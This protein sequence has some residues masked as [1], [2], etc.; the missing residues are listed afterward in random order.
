MYEYGGIETS[1][2]LANILMV[3]FGFVFLFGIFT[4]LFGCEEE[5]DETSPLEH[6]DEED[7]FAVL[8]GDE[9]YL[10]AHCTLKEEPLPTPKTSTRTRVMRSSEQD[11]GSN[12]PRVKPKQQAKPC[13]TDVGREAA[14]GL[15]S[16][17]YKKSDANRLVNDMLTQN[18][19]MTSEEVVIEV[20]QK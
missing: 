15:V 2:L 14:M 3:I 9:Q 20:F 13:T 16:L 18:P 6:I 5:V 7:I 12:S 8:T 11:S 4:G 1:H 19:N 10:A 17:G